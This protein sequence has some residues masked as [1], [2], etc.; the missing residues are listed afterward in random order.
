MTIVARTV[1]PFMGIQHEQEKHFPAQNRTFLIITYQAYNAFGLIGPEQNGVAILDKDQGEVLCD[2]IGVQDTG[3]HGASVKQVE[4]FH[5]IL[6][7]PWEKFR[8]FVNR[9]EQ[10]RY[11][12]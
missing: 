7:M 11:E 10:L 12:L 2:Q 9:Q 1:H 3:Y 8:A 5:E 6:G 4:L